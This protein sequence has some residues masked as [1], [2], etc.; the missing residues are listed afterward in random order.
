MALHT[1]D[2]GE[3]GNQSTSEVTYTGYSRIAI[4]RSTAGWTVT[5]NSVSPVNPVEWG[6]MTAGVPSEALY[7]SVGIASAG[8]GKILYKGSL[9]PSVKID[10]GVVPRLRTTSTITEE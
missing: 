9:T 8:G 6:E 3:D 1:A 7:A 4:N 5:G 2:P 10:I